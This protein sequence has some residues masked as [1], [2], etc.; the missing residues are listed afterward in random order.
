MVFANLL[1]AVIPHAA[2]KD[3]TPIEIKYRS[4]EDKNAHR[5]GHIE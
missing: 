5:I 2:R 1:C 4:A 3:R